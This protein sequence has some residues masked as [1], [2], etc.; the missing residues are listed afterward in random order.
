MFKIFTFSMIW[1]LNN[2]LRA[3]SISAR[4]NV[5]CRGLSRSMG[6]GNL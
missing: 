5:I 4:L 6:T 2:Y 3:N 1:E